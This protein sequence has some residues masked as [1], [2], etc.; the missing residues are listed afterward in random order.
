MD[1]G[2]AW[3][4]RHGGPLSGIGTWIISP[5]LAGAGG[6]KSGMLATLS[7]YLWVCSVRRLAQR[8][9]ALLAL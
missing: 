3:R 2:G 4:L 9:A 7:K 5:A 8:Q 6:T 1:L